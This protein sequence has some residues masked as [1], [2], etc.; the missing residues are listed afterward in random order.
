VGV[1]HITDRI[2]KLGQ[3]LGLEVGRVC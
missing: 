3:L 2:E 1:G